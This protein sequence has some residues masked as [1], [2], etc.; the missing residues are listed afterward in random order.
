M[1]DQSSS[2]MF[3]IVFILPPFLPA[4]LSF[5]SAL[6]YSIFS[7]PYTIL[8]NVLALNSFDLSIKYFQVQV[9]TFLSSL[10]MVAFIN[11]QICLELFLF[12]LI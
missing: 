11:V 7:C 6:R 3:Q 2:V 4:L 10:N 1:G 9:F 12:L 5:F 8:V